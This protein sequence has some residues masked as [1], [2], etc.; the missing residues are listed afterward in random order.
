MRIVQLGIDTYWPDDRPV[1]EA[2]YVVKFDVDEQL[3]C[4]TKIEMDQSNVVM[5]ELPNGAWLKIRPNC[6]GANID[7]VS[8]PPEKYPTEFP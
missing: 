5:L 7:V 1:E 4:S 6:Y 3:S 8:F 2:R